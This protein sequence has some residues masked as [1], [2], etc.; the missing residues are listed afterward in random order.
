LRDLLE[1]YLDH[2]DVMHLLGVVLKDTGKLEA[3]LAML[4]AAVAQCPE[5]AHYQYHYGLS[6]VETGMLETAAGAFSKAVSIDPELHDAR[7]YLAKSLKD[8]GDLETF[9]RVNTELLEVRTDHVKASYN[10]ANLFTMSRIGWRTRLHC[11]RKYCP[12]NQHIITPGSTV[13]SS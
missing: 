4:Q 1:A 12:G 6:L 9:S 3:S 11:T 8:C 7:Y 5:S 13:Q 10:L 2:S